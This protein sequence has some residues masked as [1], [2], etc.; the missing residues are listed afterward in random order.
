MKRT[1]SLILAL[2]LSILMIPTGIITGVAAGEVSGEYTPEEGAMP[3]STVEQFEKIGTGSYYLAND[4]DFGGKVYDRG[5]IINKLNGT[6]DGCGHSITNINIKTDST[7]ADAGII[8]GGLNSS[9]IKNLVVGTSTNRAKIETT[10]SGKC[11]AGLIGSAQVGNL[12]VEN[13]KLYVDVKS[14]STTAGIVGYLAATDTALI[15]NCEVN[16]SVVCEGGNDAGGI[17]G[18]IKMSVIVRIEDCVNNAA[19]TLQNIE[20]VKRGVGGIIATAENG[21]SVVNCVN[22][23]NITTDANHAG[24]IFGYMSI[25]GE[26]NPVLIQKCSNYGTVSGM[27]TDKN[28]YSTE[29][30]TKVLSVA[31]RAAIGGIFGGTKEFDDNRPNTITI[32]K[33]MNYGTVKTNGAGAAAI[34]GK[35]IHTKNSDANTAIKVVIKDTGNVGKIEYGVTDVEVGA[36]VSASYTRGIGSISISNCY[37]MG[38]TNSSNAYAGIYN[39][40]DPY[41]ATAPDSPTPQD[42]T[43]SDFY[44]LGDSYF[45]AA[46]SAGSSANATVSN[47]VKCTAEQFKSGEVAYNLGFNFGQKIG[48]QDYPVPGGAAV[49][50][51][52]NASTPYANLKTLS[53]K[54]G[55]ASA[56]YVQVT[57][58]NEQEKQTVRFVVVVDSALIENAASAEM[59]ITFKKQGEADLSYTMLNGD[60]KLFKSV[61]ADGTLCLASDGCAILGA[62]VK[63]I[64]AD[65]WSSLEMRL[66]V[67]D[68]AGAQIDLASASGAYSK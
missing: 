27:N 25:S 68:A 1:L 36:F 53:T 40:Y 55:G 39:F 67:K 30:G 54:T 9:T 31:R 35:G 51:T 8:S 11:A 46:N 62:V 7:G 63:D 13:V 66:T 2:V 20:G 5:Y 19:V 57:E 38:T 37:N 44:F 14:V 56:A 32:D 59:V 50:Q 15:K 34:M 17:I 60:I 21:V 16:G 49:V 64:P 28:T 6:L 29:I 22:K 45:Y 3:I 33:C 42:V 23:G 41:K 24:G 10:A 61:K 4:I 43:V 48:L 47:A 26:N 65:A 18:R 58:K 12:T 52:G